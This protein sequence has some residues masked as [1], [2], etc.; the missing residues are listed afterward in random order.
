MEKKNKEDEK[1]LK[2]YG[3]A[4]RD[5]LEIIKRTKENKGDKDKNGR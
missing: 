5:I 2:E 1:I 4:G 3:R